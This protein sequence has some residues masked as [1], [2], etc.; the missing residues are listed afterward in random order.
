[1]AP[2]TPTIPPPGPDSLSSALKRNI[3]ALEHRRRQE[4]AAAT[5]EERIAEVITR[6]TGSMLFV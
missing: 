1:M 4:A 3:Q 6:F 5:R 2:V